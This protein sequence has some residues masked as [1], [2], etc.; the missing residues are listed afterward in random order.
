MSIITKV[1][2]TETFLTSLNQVAVNTKLNY[3]KS[4]VRFQKFCKSYQNNMT[5]EEL[6]RE[7][8]IIK[9]QDEDKY[10]DTL[11]DILQDFIAES[12]KTLSGNSIKTLF[13]CLRGYLYHLGVRTNPQDIKMML[14]FP[15]IE[16]EEKYPLSVDELRLIVD[17][18]SRLPF[19]KACFLA[20]SSSGMRIG[21]VL[22]V[23]KSDL[24][25]KE[26]I[27]IYIRASKSKNGKGRTV[28]IS[29]ECQNE[30]EKYIDTLNDDDFVFYRGVSDDSKIRAS[31]TARALREACDRLG[32][33]MKYDNDRYKINT[34]SLRAFFFTQAVRKHGENYAHRM[35]G[36][37]G[38]LMQYD[39]MNDD[40]KLKMYKELEPNLAVYATT[41]A[42]LE[43]ER[44][45]LQQTK[46]N[47]ELKEEMAELKHQLAQQ[48]LD[49]VDR[50][51]NEDRIL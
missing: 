19:R 33:D 17:H 39:R 14:K 20:E 29:K 18:F 2:S 1:K 3:K 4:V 5:P 25:F 11:Y 27:E 37:G 13:S 47:K 40:E 42:D 41:K 43:I 49:I 12:H 48:G 7:L 21:E 8:L 15:R 46:E 50:L 30:L 34:H 9:K 22:Q 28:Y 10:I 35:T 16:T 6:C 24:I 32:L 38:Y 45:K 31:N 36:H 26:R 51:K 44:L 23:K